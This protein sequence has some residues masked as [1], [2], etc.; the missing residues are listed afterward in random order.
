MR[1][2]NPEGTF[3]FAAINNTAARAVTEKLLL[4]LNDVVVVSS[5][6]WLSQ[7]V[8]WSRLPGVGAVGARLLYPDQS[9]QHAGIVHGLHDAVVGHAVRSLA[10]TARHAV[11][12]ACQRWINQLSSSDRHRESPGGPVGLCAMPVDP[13]MSF[14]LLVSKNHH[15]GGM[16]LSPQAGCLC[17]A[18][19]FAS[20][21]RT[22]D[23]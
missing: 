10:N 22:V 1:V 8:G 15:C 2:P 3:N 14:Y 18:C 21:L 16:G 12:P 11:V 23:R 9:V 13:S 5:P 17:D 20:L 7:M 19:P 4:L 6:R